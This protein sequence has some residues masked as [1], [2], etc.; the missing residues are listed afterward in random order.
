MR[1]KILFYISFVIIIVLSGFIWPHINLP[2]E[3]TSIIGEYSKNK[4]HHNN[5]LLRYLIFIL[6]PILSFLLYLL[7]TNQN[8]IS[9]FL[10]KL[11]QIENEKSIINLN[12]I[13]IFF[14]FL[15]ILSI[16]F[17]SINLPIH[18]IDSFHEGQ[19]LSAAYKYR[20]DNKLWSGSYVTV[21]IIYEAITSNLVW[22]LFENINIGAVRFFKLFLIL[23]L[24]ILLVIFSYQLTKATKLDGFLECL[25]F[26]VIS[27]ISVNFVNYL[28]YGGYLIYREI[29]VLLS[30][31]IFF[32]F[33]LKKFGSKYFL[34]ILGPLSCLSIFYSLDRGF[35]T[36]IFILIFF[37]YLLINKELKTLISCLLSV[38]LCWLFSFYYLGNEFEYFIQNT[39]LILQE[40]KQ[41][42][43]IIHPIPFTGEQNSTRSFKSLFLISLGL[44]IAFDLMTQKKTIFTKNFTLMLFVISIL[45]FFT[46]GYAIGRADGPHIRSTFGYTIILYSLIITYLLFKFFEKKKFINNINKFSLIISLFLIILLFSKSIIFTNISSFKT[47]LQNYVNYKDDIFLNDNEKSFV[48]NAKNILIKTKCVQLFTNDVSMLYLIRKPNC[49]KF[50]FPINIGSIKNQKVLINQLKDVNIILADNDTGEFSPNYRLPILK[51]YINQNYNILYKED[52]WLILELKK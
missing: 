18:K 21:G 3:E 12:L 48:K 33:L 11:S 16:E 24:K 50:Y 14:F 51:E 34:L 28:F 52:K 35:V 15:F 1:K 44:I 41:I 10:E 32:Q 26:I 36:N 30:V 13:Y 40:I 29:P 47:R 20:L 38:V 49:T 7:K 22:N 27:F 5:D 17:L 46:Y 19:Q 6:I 37:I 45:C 8:F 43:G 2:Y 39:T 25:F 42:G 9:N 23:I 4:Y 31:I